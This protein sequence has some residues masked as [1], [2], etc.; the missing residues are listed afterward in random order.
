MS[1]LKPYAWNIYPGRLLYS[2]EGTQGI[3]GQISEAYSSGLV[4]VIDIETGDEFIETINSVRE[5]WIPIEDALTAENEALKVEINELKNELQF[6]I[7][8]NEVNETLICEKIECNKQLEADNARLQGALEKCVHQFRA[9]AFMHKQKPKTENTEYKINKNN[10][11]A[12][13][14]R[15]A[16]EGGK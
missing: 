6:Q 11:M 4:R 13:L 7:R 14:C 3:R 12:E 1:E 8:R 2:I 5:A 15:K 16:L 10:E 9:Y